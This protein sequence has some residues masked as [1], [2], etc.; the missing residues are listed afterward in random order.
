M[1]EFPQI[2]ERKTEGQYDIHPRKWKETAS[3]ITIVKESDYIKKLY[4]LSKQENYKFLRK[5]RLI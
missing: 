1:A 2:Y 5:I 3:L 4:S